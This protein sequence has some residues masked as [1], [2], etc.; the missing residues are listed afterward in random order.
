MRHDTRL[1][2]AH[3]R[4]HR[5]GMGIQSADNGC[6]SATALDMVQRGVAD[7]Q[8]D[9]II[10]RGICHINTREMSSHSA[11]H[12]SCKLSVITSL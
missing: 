3:V 6:L 4:T 10:L 11:A 9:K 5:S 12:L 1:L 2:L 8:K 7:F